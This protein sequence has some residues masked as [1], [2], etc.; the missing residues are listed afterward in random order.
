MIENG[1]KINIK[2]RISKSVNNPQWLEPYATIIQEGVDKAQK[3]FDISDEEMLEFL[4]AFPMLWS[5]YIR[6]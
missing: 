1:K 4:E 2:K 3:K 5:V 6:R